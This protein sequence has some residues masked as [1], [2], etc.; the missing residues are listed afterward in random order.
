MA[1]PGG[2]RELILGTAVAL[3]LSVALSFGASYGLNRY[4]GPIDGP[5][6]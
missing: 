5:M 1:N 2:K 4:L 3:L 6:T